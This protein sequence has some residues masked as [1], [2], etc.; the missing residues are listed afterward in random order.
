MGRKGG[1]SIGAGGGTPLQSIEGLFA[2]R[3]GGE[4]GKGLH[5]DLLA[6]VAAG[7]ALALGHPDQFLNEIGNHGDQY[8][9]QTDKPLRRKLGCC[10]HQK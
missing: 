1:E 7:S 6:T 2:V 9:D 5:L 8:N 3:A 10:L 4:H